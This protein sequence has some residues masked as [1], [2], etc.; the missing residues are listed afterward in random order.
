M[1]GPVPHAAGPALLPPGGGRAATRPCGGCHG[2]VG[3][4]GVARRAARTASRVGAQATR[5]LPAAISTICQPG[6][7][8]AAAGVTITDGAPESPPTWVARAA[9]APARNASAP[10]TRPAAHQRRRAMAVWVVLRV[11]L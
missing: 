1:A 6:M 11:L 7:P 9:G 5:A 4:G 2:W 10:A 8:P 3:C